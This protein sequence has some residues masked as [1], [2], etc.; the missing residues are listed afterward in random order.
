MNYY[1]T[2]EIRRELLGLLKPH[3]DDRLVRH[4]EQY[5]SPETWCIPDDDDKMYIEK[6]V[7]LNR[8][9]WHDAWDAFNSIVE[10]SLPDYRIRRKTQ[11]IVLQQQLKVVFKKEVKKR[12]LRRDLDDS[13]LEVDAKDERF[14]EATAQKILF[15]VRPPLNG[16]ERENVR[17][18]LKSAVNKHYWNYLEQHK[19]D[20]EI[21]AE[22]FTDTRDQ[23][24]RRSSGWKFSKPHRSLRHSARSIRKSRHS[25]KGAVKKHS[26]KYGNDLG[27]RV[28]PNS[29]GKGNIPEYG[30]NSFRSQ[31]SWMRD[32][33]PTPNRALFH[34]GGSPPPYP[35]GPYGGSNWMNSVTAGFSPPGG[36]PMGSYWNRHHS[37]RW[38]S[39]SHSHTSPNDNGFTPTTPF[40]A[41]YTAHGGV[42][43]TPPPPPPPPSSPQFGG[44]NKTN[45]RGKTTRG[46]E[47][48][49]V[50][51][52]TNVFL[53]ENSKKFNIQRP[54]RR[55]QEYLNEQLLKNALSFFH[56][57]TYG[58]HN[59]HMLRAH[60][61]DVAF[62]IR[63]ACMVLDVSHK[64]FPENR[65]FQETMASLDVP[66]F[67]HYMKL[68]NRIECKYMGT[69]FSGLM[70]GKC[71]IEAPDHHRY[72]A[73]IEL[74]YQWV[75]AQ[76]IYLLYHPP[77]STLFPSITGGIIRIGKKIR[78]KLNSDNEYR[79]KALRQISTHLIWDPEWPENKHGAIPTKV[80][81]HLLWKKSTPF[82][83][84]PHFVK[85]GEPDL[86]LTT[87]DEVEVITVDDDG[88]SEPEEYASD[89]TS[90]S[91]FDSDSE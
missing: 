2:Y 80:A 5:K 29:G 23:T 82:T 67:I 71:P 32:I 72:I 39:P 4:V 33:P 26:W 42:N 65:A 85:A 87:N 36:F 83:G 88:N 56:N 21:V 51:H 53:P 79:T 48:K 62:A 59:P 54:G 27:N 18:A 13:W 8:Y 61:T 25:P 86:K 70:N 47:S 20:H 68:D 10:K 3:I 15:D 7:K 74:V 9:S 90:E 57:K 34:N 69:D 28:T 37:Q 75:G 31:E 76:P 73:I 45:K 16:Q 11:D 60:E 77:S 19:E 63:H 24:K 84:T 43:P 64:K 6:L 14:V 12:L 46:Q 78:L 58:D 66:K 55:W 41:D 30:A 35:N 1:I 89:T 17:H 38:V 50:F 44:G 22:T 81:I 40:H 91:D 49:K 52:Y